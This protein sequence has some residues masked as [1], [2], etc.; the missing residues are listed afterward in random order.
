MNEIPA[1]ATDPGTAQAAPLARLV[2]DLGALAANYALLQRIAAPAEV[3]AVVKANAYG[4]GLGP[5][6]ARLAAA[7]CHSFFVDSLAEGQDLRAR[8]PQARIFVLSAAA[9]AAE[10]CRRERLTPVLNTLA[11]VRRWAG[12]APRVPAALQLDTGMTR[13][14]L[15]ADEVAALVADRDLLAALKLELLMTQLACADEPGH[16]LNGEQLKRFAALRAQLPAAPT[17]I[18]N[19]A[20]TLLGAAFRGDLVRPGIALYGG[21]PFASGPNPMRPVVRLEARVLQIHALGQDAAV[22]YGAAYTARAPARIATVAVGY[23][24]GYPRALG[25]RGYACAGGR[26]LPVVGRVS[27]NLTA[28][29]VS[30]LP[31]AA[32]APGDYVEMLGPGVALEELAERAGT[33]GYEILVRLSPGLARHWV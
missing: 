26:R 2:I 15:S 18:G 6:A 17:S 29:D 23:A 24:D 12:Q 4:L 9:D 20:G 5:V 31:P 21:R 33:I 22:G 13:A 10:V 25:G 14:G 27:M 11:E 32:L 1:A 16:A 7:G 19:S 28:L 8:L 30:L 3:G